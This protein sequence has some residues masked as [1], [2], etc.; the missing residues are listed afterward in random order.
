MTLLNDYL[1]KK[2]IYDNHP[3]I[4]GA[5]CL[6][7][8]QSKA[9]CQ[10]CKEICVHGVFND[11]E[12]NWNKCSNCGICAA[13]CPAGCISPS[14]YQSDKMLQLLRSQK[15]SASLSCSQKPASAGLS[16]HCLAAYPWEYIALL[17]LS[18]HVTILKADCSGCPYASAMPLFENALCNVRH[19]LGDERYLSS[20]AVTVDPSELTIN[21]YSRRDVFGRFFSRTASTVSIL[22][23]ET[24]GASIRLWRRLLKKRLEN[25]SN[26]HE[27]CACSEWKFPLFTDCCNACGI[28]TEVCP[29]KALYRIRDENDPSVMHM[30]VFPWKCTSCGLCHTICPYLG[31]SEPQYQKVRAPSAPALCSV[32]CRLCSRCR[33]PVPADWKGELCSRCQGELG[34]NMFTSS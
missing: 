21:R 3:S 32:S 8:I 1:T 17:A 30:A 28:C 31:I 7:T 24:A 11:T 16:L 26:S 12:P 9:P 4:A 22:L 25:Q 15:P 19:F 10:V 5:R 18:G 14:P 2:L 20:V 23:P 13:T 34:R 29:V 27:P 33:E 6:N